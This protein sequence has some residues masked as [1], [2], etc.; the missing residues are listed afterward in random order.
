MNLDCWKCIFNDA[1]RLVPIK[2]TQGLRWIAKADENWRQRLSRSKSQVTITSLIHYHRVM[3]HHAH[4]SFN[5]QNNLWCFLASNAHSVSVVQRLR[6]KA[7]DFLL[8]L[9]QID[10]IFI[11]KS[12]IN[13]LSRNHFFRCFLLLE[14][15]PFP[16]IFNLHLLIVST[17]TV[18]S[19]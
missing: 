4:S 19:M 5:F 10:I 11:N 18:S 1:C 15:L 3:H 2:C 14:F 16:G 9:H 8:S 13:Y 6:A 17:I 12:L 7:F